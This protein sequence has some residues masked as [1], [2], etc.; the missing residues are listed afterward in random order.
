MNCRRAHPTAHIRPP[1]W[2]GRFGEASTLLAEGDYSIPRLVLDCF[3]GYFVFRLLIGGSLIWR[4]DC[5]G[6]ESPQQIVALSEAQGP[7]DADQCVG[8]RLGKSLWLAAEDA[9]GCSL[10]GGPRSRL[11]MA[12]FPEAEAPSM[13]RQDAQERCW[14]W[15]GFSFA[16]K[17]AYLCTPE[18]PRPVRK[19]IVEM[20][21][22]HVSWNT[23]P[24]DCADVSMAHVQ[25]FVGQ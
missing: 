22:I 1:G 3:G 2:N 15:H 6:R 25:L 24:V 20:I 9:L 17:G 11:G 10:F 21:M 5:F 19:F 14:P 16:R 4:F 7:C 8:P 13:G 18:A 12:T 23:V